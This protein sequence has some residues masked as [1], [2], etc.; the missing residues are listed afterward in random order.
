MR[1]HETCDSGVIYFVTVSQKPHQQALA[2]A[3][4]RTLSELGE[5]DLETMYFQKGKNLRYRSHVHGKLA[6][7]D[8]AA[9]IVANPQ[10]RS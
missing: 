5:A 3:L 10:T 1:R 7:F 6:E 2:S 8:S 4:H 9:A